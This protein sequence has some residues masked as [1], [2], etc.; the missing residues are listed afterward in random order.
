MVLYEHRLE[1]VSVGDIESPS[2]VT[3]GELTRIVREFEEKVTNGT[4]D[5]DHFLTLS[6]IEELWGKLIGDTNVLYSDMLTNI[7]NNVDE[8]DLV[9][10][11]KEN[12][13]PKESG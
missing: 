2:S 13:P 3:I 9:R 4:S 6:E 11:K 7:I 12:T 8:K 10:K 1:V 5:P